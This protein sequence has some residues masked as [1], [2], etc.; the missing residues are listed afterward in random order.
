MSEY[1]IWLEK[2][3]EDEADDKL[4]KKYNDALFDREVEKAK[5]IRIG[6]N[7]DTSYYIGGCI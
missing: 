1:E 7:F 4:A 5:S 3:L 2:H 6:Y